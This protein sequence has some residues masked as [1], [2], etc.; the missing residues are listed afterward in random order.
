M[1]GF[2]ACAR[3]RL[4][5]SPG[6]RAVRHLFTSGVLEHGLWQT[7]FTEPQKLGFAKACRFLAVA[8]GEGRVEEGSRC[9][10]PFRSK[11]GRLSERVIKQTLAILGKLVKLDPSCRS[12]GSYAGHRRGASARNA[13]E[14]TGGKTGAPRTDSS[15]NLRLTPATRTGGRQRTADEPDWDRRFLGRPA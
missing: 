7:A 4:R 5:S 9:R 12:T 10:L 2:W 15:V 1:V 14:D 6:C 11:S 3:R 13:P 8:M